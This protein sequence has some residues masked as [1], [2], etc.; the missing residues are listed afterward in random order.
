MTMPNVILDV[1]DFAENPGNSTDC[2]EALIEQKQ[3]FFNFKV[4]LFGIPWYMGKDNSPFFLRLL[5]Q[6]GDWIQIGLHGWKHTQNECAVWTIPEAVKKIDR[7]YKMGCFVPIFRAPN[8]II[9]KETICAL[10]YCGFALAD[11]SVINPIP[12]TKVK[13]YIIPRLGA[14]HTHSWEAHNGILKTIEEGLWDQ[15]TKFYFIHDLVK[16]EV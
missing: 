3:K 9:N 2:L 12:Q 4:T 15:E 1:D 10:E 14:V 8:F 13:S 11:H 6:Y 7:A 16:G 5:E